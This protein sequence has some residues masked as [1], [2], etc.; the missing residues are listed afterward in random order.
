VTDAAWKSRFVERFKESAQYVN[1]VAYWLDSRGLR[2]RV[3]PC[4][5]RPSHDQ[6]K[7]Y[8]DT[9]D[10]EV[11]LLVEVKHRQLEFTC[12]DDYPYATVVVDEVYKLDAKRSQLYAY[13]ILN[14]AA[15][16]AVVVPRHTWQQWQR[17]SRQD[18]IA[19]R[20]CEFYVVDKGLCNF[21]ELPKQEEVSE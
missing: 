7:D 14:R 9:G 16:H 6:W 13:V 10:I 5:L 15:T 12:H 18:H 4:A 1:Q 21:V 2:A 17:M 3:I 8:A 11:T 19:G 20:V